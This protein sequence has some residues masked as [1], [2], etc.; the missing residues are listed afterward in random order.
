MVLTAGEGRTV[1]LW[2]SGDGAPV[3]KPMT[4]PHRVASAAFSP[5]GKTILILTFV[6]DTSAQLWSGPSIPGG[7][8]SRIAAWIQVLT[9]LELEDSGSV[10][11]LD[12]QT[13]QERQ[14]LLDALGGPPMP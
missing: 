9:G 10:R 8:A 11:F 7:D 14:R 2:H 12:A 4:H 13:W 1:R 5:D 6:H 3:G